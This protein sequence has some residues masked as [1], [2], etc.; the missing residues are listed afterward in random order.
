MAFADN[1]LHDITLL[2]TKE[3]HN[4]YANPTRLISFFLYF[5]K[6]QK[7]NRTQTIIQST[8]WPIF[9]PDPE[10][11]VNKTLRD[12][13]YSLRTKEN[14]DADLLHDLAARAE[15]I[16]SVGN[17]MVKYQEEQDQDHQRGEMNYAP[18]SFYYKDDT[19]NKTLDKDVHLETVDEELKVTLT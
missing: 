19:N 15:L 1:T 13:K 10:W 6:I 4:A 5:C 11:S 3:Q 8:G 16:T 18:D 9:I 7:I 12:F 2:C 14:N 17:R